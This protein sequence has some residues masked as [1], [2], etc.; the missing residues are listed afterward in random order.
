MKILRMLILL[1]IVFGLGYYTGQKP[2][3]VKQRLR[4]LS[5]QVLENTIGYDQDTNLQR[6]MLA[7]KDGFL[8]G[9]AYLLDHHFEEASGEFERALHHLD[10]AVELDPQGPLAQKIQI[11][12]QKVREAQQSLAQGHNLPPHVLDELRQE[13]QSVMP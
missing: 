1:G 4:D 8:E 6:Q 11:V 7:A 10:Q 12:K 3:V 2:D 5:G 13:L 9:R